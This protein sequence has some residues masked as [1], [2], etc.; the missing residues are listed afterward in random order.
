MNPSLPPVIQVWRRATADRLPPEVVR[1]DVTSRGPEPWV[2][3]SPFYPHGGIPVPLSPGVESATVEGI[4]Q[5]L[6]VFEHQ[7]VDIGAFTNTTLRHLK[8]GGN[9]RGRVLGHRAGLGSA[10]LLGYVA[11]RYAI[12]LPAYRWVLD[13][14][15]PAHVAELRTLLT[16]S[17][18]A[19]LDFETNDDVE[20]ASRPLSHA[21]LVRAY[22]LDAWPA[23]LSERR[24]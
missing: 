7:D 3:F 1:I 15:L 11:A 18:L 17:P 22:L 2:R 21:S 24:T 6:K 12:Y 19:L 8:R 14:C 20:D 9:G 10:D 4:W 16:E 23:S 5:G 13:H